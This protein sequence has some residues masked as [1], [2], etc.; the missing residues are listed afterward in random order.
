MYWQA[1]I[2]I[3]RYQP[4]ISASLLAINSL[5]DEDFIFTLNHL[6]TIR[7]KIPGIPEWLTIFNSYINKDLQ[8]LALQFSTFILLTS[9]C[10]MPLSSSKGFA[11]I[12]VVSISGTAELML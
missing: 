9:F 5:A 2:L 7:K 8:R 3:R 12:V 6:S 4:L 11:V 10:S 1:L